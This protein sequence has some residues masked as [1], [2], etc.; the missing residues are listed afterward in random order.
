MQ[1][2]TFGQCD[3]VN[4]VLIK[5]IVCSCPNL[6]SLFIMSSNITDI[7]LEQISESKEISENF[8]NCR[9]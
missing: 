3:N 5:N 2:I 6:I 8:L 4:S 1:R 9:M 7:G